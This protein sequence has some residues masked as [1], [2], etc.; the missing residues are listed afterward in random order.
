MMKITDIKINAPIIQ[1]EHTEKAA[2]ADLTDKEE[3]K[4]R[5]A[6]KK[7]EGQFLTFMLKA[8]ENTVP[9]DEK[10]NSQSMA[11]MMFSSVLGE[12]IAESGG[13][14]LADFIYQS[15]KANGSDALKNMPENSAYNTIS[16]IK[17][18]DFNH[19]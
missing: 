8:M 5:D 17:L 12:N 6:S 9:K 14:G 13:I 15:L 11:T 1:K 18:T 19:E 10:E 3:K 7:L 16:N 4:L 2:T